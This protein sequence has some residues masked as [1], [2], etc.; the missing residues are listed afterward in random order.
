MHFIFVVSFVILA[1]S[2]LDT[3]GWHLNCT[4]PKYDGPCRARVRSYYFSN[5]T[6]TCRK[7]WYGGCEGNPNNFE[8]KKDCKRTCEV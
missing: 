1:C 8:R 6:K 2:F 4:Y 3:E 7:F 5:R